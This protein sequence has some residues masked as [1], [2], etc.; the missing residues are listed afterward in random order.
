MS[1]VKEPNT[2]FRYGGA[3]EPLSEAQYQAA[4]KRE[5]RVAADGGTWTLAFSHEAIA[6]IVPGAVEYAGI[7]LSVTGDDGECV[8]TSVTDPSRFPELYMPRQNRK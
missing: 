1:W 5:Y 2:Q 6:P 4:V 8:Y 3:G 7:S